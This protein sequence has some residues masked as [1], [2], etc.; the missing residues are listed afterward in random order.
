MFFEGLE[1]IPDIATKKDCSIFVVPK[2]KFTETAKIIEKFE[3]K[4]KIIGFSLTPS[5]DKK[6]ITIEQVRDL[7]QDLNTREKRD[8]FIMI[9]PVDRLNDASG[10]ALLKSLEEPHEHYHFILLTANPSDVM[11]TILSRSG[12]YLFKTKGTIDQA[13]SEKATVIEDA[14]KLIAA[15]PKTLLEIADKIAKSKDSA[16]EKALTLL[17]TAIEL[18]Y[19]SYFKTKN[20][21]FLKKL[22]KLIEAYTNISNNGHIKIHLIADLL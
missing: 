4:H 18:C 7:L 14:K 13:P 19:K 8:R 2:D 15:N 21:I 12:I 5:E 3:Q 22:P 1:Q 16:R 20:Q 9:S 11:P 17:S 10:N 6:D